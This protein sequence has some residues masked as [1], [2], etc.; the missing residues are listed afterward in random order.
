MNFTRAHFRRA[1]AAVVFRPEIDASHQLRV[2]LSEVHVVEA[3][4][5]FEVAVGG[6]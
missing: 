1:G 3:V 2:R 4:D 6:D 5:V